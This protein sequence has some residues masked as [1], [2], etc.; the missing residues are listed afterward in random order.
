MRNL[1]ASIDLT[2]I[3]LVLVSLFPGCVFW[4]DFLTLKGSLAKDQEFAALVL[5]IT[6]DKA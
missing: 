4:L 5:K 6:R 1:E 3:E 2:E